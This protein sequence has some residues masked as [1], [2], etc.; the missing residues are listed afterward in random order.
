MIYKQS[1]GIIIKI[2][3]LAL[4]M[5]GLSVYLCPNNSNNTE[6]LVMIGWPLLVKNMKY[7]VLPIGRKKSERYAKYLIFFLGQEKEGKS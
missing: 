6:I 1:L 7:F 3:L 2:I 5:K 4:S